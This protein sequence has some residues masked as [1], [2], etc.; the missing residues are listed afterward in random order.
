MT[1]DE[2]HAAAVAVRFVRSCMGLAF[3]C[4]ICNVSTVYKVISDSL[5]FSPLVVLFKLNNVIVVM[6][7]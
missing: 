1:A 6:E 4:T 5:C 2:K 3:K 7:T